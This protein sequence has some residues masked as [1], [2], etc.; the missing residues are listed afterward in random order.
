LRFTFNSIFPSMSSLPTLP[1]FEFCFVNPRQSRACDHDHS[2]PEDD[3]WF[4]EELAI[5][6]LVIA[7]I[8]TARFAVFGSQLHQSGKAAKVGRR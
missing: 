5:R 7:Q 3:S 1:S 8:F 6:F 4:G 2:N